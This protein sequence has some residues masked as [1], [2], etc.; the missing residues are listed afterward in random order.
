MFKPIASPFWT[1]VHFGPS[2]WEW[3]AAKNSKGYGTRWHNGKLH[4]AHRV[5][6]SEEHGAIP[7]GM[8]VLHRCD[9]PSCVRLEHLFLGTDDDNK[10][11]MIAKGRQAKAQKNHRNRVKTHCK[12]GHEFSPENTHMTKRG[13]RHCR[14][15]NR[16]RMGKSCPERRKALGY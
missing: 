8:M 6:W 3:M 13:T 14:S 4:K 1:Q 10:A 9:N 2:C 12:R 15:C 16:E 11:D 7:V 5:A